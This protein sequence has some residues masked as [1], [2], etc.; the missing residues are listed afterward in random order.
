MARMVFNTKTTTALVERLRWDTTFRCLCGWRRVCDVPSEST[1]SRAF[2]ECAE[3]ALPARLHAAPLE[4][5]YP[6][7]LVGPISRDSTAIEAA[8]E[9][10]RQGSRRG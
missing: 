5:G 10:V 4:E 1:Y 6:E 3:A 9:P 7:Q 2:K 8:E